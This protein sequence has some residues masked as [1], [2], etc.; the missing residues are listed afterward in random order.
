MYSKILL[1]M[2]SS[3]TAFRAAE[4]AVQLKKQ[5]KSE[6]V[7]FHSIEHHMIPQEIP[8]SLPVNNTY[9][10]GIPAEVYNEIEEAHID[11]GKKI[12]S[13]IED[14]FQKAN[15][16][17]ETRLVRDKKPA[18]Y[19]LDVIKDEGFDLVVLGCKGSHSKLET[20][21]LGTVAEKVVNKGT[22]DTLIVR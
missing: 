5:W 2:D 21:L 13:D 12:L 18:K 20:I 14:L 9:S 8:L 4:K 6:V 17:I 1:A 15:L 10:Y 22:T 11:R 7:A 3:K 19:I 16:E